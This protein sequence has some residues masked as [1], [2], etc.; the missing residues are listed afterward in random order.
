L[1]DPLQVTT[2]QT[3]ASSTVIT[4]NATLLL[5]ATNSTLLNAFTVNGGRT[6]T[7]TGTG[8]GT[9]VF[10]TT[11]NSQIF[12]VASG[13]TLLITNTTLI[14]TNNSSSLTFGSGSGTVTIGSSTL[15]I[16]GNNGV[17]IGHN[18]TF[19]VGSGGVVTN[20]VVKLAFNNS[21][22][23]LTNGGSLFSPT[24]NGGFFMGSATNSG[25]QV[26]IGSSIGSQTSTFNAGATRL[27]IGGYFQ[28]IGEFQQRCA[29][30][31]Q[32]SCHQLQRCGDRR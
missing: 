4:N 30:F 2:G 22:L 17:G 5:G 13:G 23:V 15:N 31:F 20:T 19:I 10:S 14:N 6:L 9:T 11:N 29:G 16:G 12:N 21:T 28:P 24:V 26:L 7:L 18:E 8:S 25:N 3:I 1:S 27:L 32:W